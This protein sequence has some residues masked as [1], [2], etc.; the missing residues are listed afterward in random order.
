MNKNLSYFLVVNFFLCQYA[1]ASSSCYQSYDYSDEYHVKT[2]IG[3]KLNKESIN[4]SGRLHHRSIKKK[5]ESYSFFWLE[6]KPFQLEEID[7]NSLNAPFL[8]RKGDKGFLIESLHTVSKDKSLH[9]Q[10]IGL[11]NLLQYSSKPGKY[12]WKSSIGKVLVEQRTDKQLIKIRRFAQFDNTGAAIDYNYLQSD[13]IIKPSNE[14]YWANVNGSESV[15][16]EIDTFQISTLTDR[17]FGMKRSD[18]SLDE[19]HWFMRLNEDTSTWVPTKPPQEN[20]PNLVDILK[21]YDSNRKYLES[22]MN[23]DGKFSKWVSENIT[24]LQNLPDILLNRGINDELSKNL[25][26]EL[27]YQDTAQSTDILAKVSLNPEILEKERFRALMGIKNT[28]AP[29]SSGSLDQLLSIGLNSTD[30]NFINNAMGMLMG[31]LAKERADRDPEQTQLIGDS[32]ATAI[33]N[34]TGRSEVTLNAAGNMEQM[35]TKEVVDAVEEKLLHD[36][37]KV[38]GRSAR[39]IQKIGKTSLSYSDF[40]ALWSNSPNNSTKKQLIESSSLAVD[41]KGNENYYGALLKIA[42]NKSTSEEVRLSS[43]NA[44]G[45]VGFGSSPEQKTSLR[46]LML[47]ERDKDISL[48]LREMFRRE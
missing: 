4:Y 37:P 26:A 36:D 11:I 8:V 1:F 48:K 27:G 18:K 30:E 39:V 9:D 45:N 24:F 2:S 14:C 13:T 22:I 16:N 42:S 20:K 35:A 29:I 6:N 33:K 32:I 25:F 38:V 17:N 46:K 15:K 10:M 23:D 34:E 40:E 31:T 28:S 44:L 41:A 7:W 43:L 12:H 3:G 47:G 19:S 5:D 21:L